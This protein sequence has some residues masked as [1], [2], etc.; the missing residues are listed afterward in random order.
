[1]PYKT[2]AQNCSAVGREKT[3]VGRES[4]KKSVSKKGIRR[5]NKRASGR[6]R[7]RKVRTRNYTNIKRRRGKDYPEKA[8]DTGRYRILL[9]GRSE[10]TNRGDE[11]VSAA[12]TRIDYHA[13]WK[14]HTLAR[15]LGNVNSFILSPQKETNVL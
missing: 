2:Q 11:K 7:C 12:R 5:R 14:N 4:G 10:Q 3:T 6:G 8:M 9:R 15:S 1:M 13:N